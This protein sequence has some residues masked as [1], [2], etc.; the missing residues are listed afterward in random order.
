RVTD[1]D[2]ENGQLLI[3]NGKG[4]KERF[5]LLPESLRTDLEQQIQQA[6]RIFLSDKKRGIAQIPLPYALHK[7]YPGAVHDFCWHYVFPSKTIG[8]D[9]RTGCHSRHHISRETLQRSFKEALNA[10]KI[11]K[12]ATLHTLRHSFA[13]HLLQH[14]YDIRTVQELLGHSSVQTTMI[15]THVLKMGSFAVKSPADAIL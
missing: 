8:K 12:R 15:Y 4:S 10:A 3:R 6:H 11:Q 1:V 5:T 14:G 2:F 7:K 13:T 9:P